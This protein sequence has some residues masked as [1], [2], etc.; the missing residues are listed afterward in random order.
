MV[1]NWEFRLV[2]FGVKVSFGYCYFNFYCEI[3]IK[4]IGSCIDINCMIEFRM[5]GCFIISLVE[6]F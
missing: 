6:V 4:W 1:N 2:K 5:I 3:L